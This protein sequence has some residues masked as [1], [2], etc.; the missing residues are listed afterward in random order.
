MPSTTEHLTQ[1]GHNEKLLSKLRGGEFDD[2]EVTVMFYIALHY[3][4][5]YLAKVHKIDDPGDHSERERYVSEKNHTRT[6]YGNYMRLKSRSVQARHYCHEFEPRE[7]EKLRDADLR[8]I[9]DRM[10]AAIGAV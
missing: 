3:V 2:W 9:R 4:D 8:V 6:L 5:A 10:L 1:A 7:L